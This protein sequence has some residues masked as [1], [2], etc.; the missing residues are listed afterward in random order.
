MK[1]FLKWAGG[2]SRLVPVIEPYLAGARRL[3]EP[4]AGSCAVFLG[5]DIPQGLMCDVNPDLVLLYTTLRD[6][7]PAFV[8]EVERLFVPENNT[9][10][11]YYCLREAFNTATG[12]DRAALFVYLNRHAFNGLCRYNASGEFNV[13]YGRYKNPGLPKAEMLAFARRVAD[14]EF[15]LSSF[16]DTMR[17]VLS[18]ARPGDV[19]YCDPPYVPLSPTASFTAYSAGGFG[20]HQQRLLAELAAELADAGIRV[21]IS[22]HDTPL[23]RDD[24]YAGADRVAGLSVRRSISASAAQRGLAPE[25]IALY[26]R[27][28]FRPA[29]TSLLPEA[30]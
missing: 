30:A 26:D 3:V 6:E 20:L 10:T 7:G 2:K 11:R 19:V 23:S 28:G 8:A 5:T 12:R 25:L 9:E 1:P 4:F 27:S 13:P 29:P 17:S 14:V 22:N 21:V 18:E 24:L 16:E 15:R